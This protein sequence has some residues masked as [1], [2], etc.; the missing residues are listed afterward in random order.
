MPTDQDASALPFGN[1]TAPSVST[2]LKKGTPTAMRI[3][4]TISQATAPDT[5]ARIALP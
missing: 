2:M 3:R 5:P 1:A 4:A